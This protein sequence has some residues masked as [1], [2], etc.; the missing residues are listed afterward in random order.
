MC[1]DLKLANIF[2]S[3]SGIVKVGDF[4]ISRSINSGCFA[5]TA[6]GTPENMSP[7]LCLAKP[8]GKPND[9]WALGCVL[10]ELLSLRT[11]FG[12]PG[13]GLSAMVQRIV[14]GHYTPLPA[15]CSP[16]M[17]LLVRL[18]LQ[19]CVPSAPFSFTGPPSHAVCVC[20]CVC[21]SPLTPVRPSIRL[22][23]SPQ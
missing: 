17:A 21:R 9:V 18:M 13:V 1:R 20:A 3:K 11:P 2:L 22:C 19:A 16:T 4:G 5:Q 15:H 7:E 12:G 8:Y 14:K 6:C 23:R 10:Y